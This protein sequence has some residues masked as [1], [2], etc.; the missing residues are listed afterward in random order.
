MLVV[1]FSLLRLNNTFGNKLEKCILSLPCVH[2]FLLLCNYL[3][4]F[5]SSRNSNFEVLK[6]EG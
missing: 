5:D 1:I 3:L 2:N 4:K 6:R